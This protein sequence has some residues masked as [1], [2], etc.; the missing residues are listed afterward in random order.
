MGFDGRDFGRGGS[1]GFGGFGGSGG[2]GGFD[3]FGGRGGSCGGGGFDGGFFGNIL[4]SVAE[5]PVDKIVSFT[6]NAI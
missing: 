1:C 6:H 3:G 2:F 4:G 5:I